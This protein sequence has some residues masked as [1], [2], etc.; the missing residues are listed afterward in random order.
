MGTLTSAQKRALRHFPGLRVYESD[1]VR[2]R[3]ALELRISLRASPD[4]VANAV[5][6]AQK[7]TPGYG[8][9]S[10]GQKEVE[11]PERIVSPSTGEGGIR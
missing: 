8:Q 9:A 4:G 5:I 11:L 7:F 10:L 6:E 3:T 1:V 2:F